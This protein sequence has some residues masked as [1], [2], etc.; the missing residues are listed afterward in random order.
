MWEGVVDAAAYAQLPD[1]VTG[2]CFRWTNKA[3]VSL[4]I[5][6]SDG[7]ET[8]SLRQLLQPELGFKLTGNATGG[9]PPRLRH[10]IPTRLPA[11][12]HA[13]PPPFFLPLPRLS[14]TLMLIGVS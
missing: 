5:D 8:E 3:D 1:V 13:E 10:P 4:S 14:L 11:A 2:A 12:V 7:R 9:L 6:W